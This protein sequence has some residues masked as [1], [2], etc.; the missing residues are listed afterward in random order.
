MISQP[1]YIVRESRNLLARLIYCSCVIQIFQKW[2]WEV[3]TRGGALHGAWMIG[4]GGRPVPNGAH[5]SARVSLLVVQLCNMGKNVKTFQVLRERQRARTGLF[6]PHVGISM[7]SLWLFFCC[8]D[9]RMALVV[10]QERCVPLMTCSVESADQAGN[11]RVVQ[12]E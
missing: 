1:R 7:E 6:L 4:S 9:L 12:I 3:G 5:G 2:L 8:E 11:P 10:E